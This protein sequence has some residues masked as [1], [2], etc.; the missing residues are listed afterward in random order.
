MEEGNTADLD[1]ERCETN[2]FYVVHDYD[3]IEEEKVCSPWREFGGYRWR[4]LVYPKGD[5]IDGY[6]SLY[7]ECGGP[8]KRDI[9]NEMPT[10]LDLSYISVRRDPSPIYSL[11]SLSNW[12]VRAQFETNLYESDHKIMKTL[13]E[14]DSYNQD[15]I[16]DVNNLEEQGEEEDDDDDNDNDIKKVVHRANC[17]FGKYRTVEGMEAFVSLQDIPKYCY[18]NNLVFKVCIKLRM[19][20][21][22]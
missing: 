15:F 22:N 4:L 9:P 14:I 17:A 7:L 5:D 6:L 16:E 18:E 3:K 1:S 12:K 10:Y 8:L 19:E 2:F 11:A 13:F 20:D 21:I